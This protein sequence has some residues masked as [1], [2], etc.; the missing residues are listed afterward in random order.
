MSFKKLLLL[1]VLSVVAFTINA[2]VKASGTVYDENNEPVIGATVIQKGNPKVGTAT[3]FDGNFTLTVPAGSHI[4]VTYVG[5][6]PVDMPAASGMK[7]TLK[8]KSDGGINLNEVVV[9]GY[10]KVDKRLFTGATT[11]VDAGKAKLD[12]VADVSRSLEGRAAGVQVQNVSGT[13]G[14]APKIRV[15]GATSIYGSSKPLWVVDGVILEDN[16]DISADDLS[17]GDATTLIASAVAGLNADDIESFQI[18]KDGSAT[19]IYGAKANAGVIVITTK[20]GRKGHT[21]INYTGEFTYRLKPNYR[22]FNIS[23]SQEQIGI[24]REMEQKGW[25]EMASLI[26]GSSTGTYGH[27]YQLMNQYNE[28]NHQFGLENTREA[29]NNYLRAAEMRNTDWFDL[30]F[31]NNIMMNHA[32]SINGGTDKGAFYTSIS[33]MNDPGWYKSSSVERYTF[34]S[35][36]IYQ[37]TDKIRVKILNS[38]S[39]RRQRAP[40]TLS[41]NVDVVSGNVSRSFDINP[42]SFA[43]NTSRALDPTQTYRRNYSDF[44]IFNELQN[45]YI[46]LNVLDVK[47]QGEL[48]IKPIIK[49]DQSL[50]INLLA[51]YRYNNS[52]QNHYVTDNSNQ[53][54]AYRA[55]VDPENAIVRSSNRYLY[56]DPD[57]PNSLPESVLPQGGML[58]Y[59]KYAITQ[60]D[61]R[62]TAQYMKNFNDKHLFQ[63]FAG[64]EASRV[65]RYSQSFQGWGIEYSGHLTTVT[66]KLFKQMEEENGNYFSDSKGYRRN[67]AFFANA[68]YSL[69]GRY[70]LNGTVRYEGSN[71]MGRTRQS[72]WLPTWNISGA[73]N[74]FEENFF[75]EAAFKKWWTYAKL[76]LS[77]SLTGES[78]PTGYANAEAL[79]YPSHPWRPETETKEMGIGLNGLANSELTYEKK[80]EFDVGI[81]LGFI[82]NRINLVFDWYKRNNFDLIGRINTAGVGGV[83]SKWANVA[84]MKSHGVEFTLTT[85]NI[86]PVRPDGFSWTTDLTFSYTHTNITKLDSRSS[87]MD[88]IRGNG[89]PLQGY[90]HRAIFSIPF[91]GLNN[92]GAPQIINEKGEV[93]TNSIN[94][95]EYEKLD[96]LKYEGPVDPTYTGGFGNMF[97]WKGFHLNVFMTYSFGNKL[98]LTPRFSSG[99]SDMTAMPKEFKNRWVIPGDEA[100]TNIPAIASVRQVYNDNQLGWGYNAYNYSTAR[101]AD[102]GFIR[103]KEVSLTY[104]LPT[105]FIRHLRLNSASVKLAATN[106]CLLYA[107]K[108]LNGEDPEFF[109]TGG[110]ASPNPKQLTLTVR[111]G[112]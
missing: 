4:L 7:I 92:Q 65:D 62:A 31:N 25:L 88:L 36:A 39:Y 19:S 74:V 102:G 57:D 100:Y 38:D 80:H 14:T 26:N 23:N 95:Q 76:R 43:L 110:V 1:F 96:F 55:G 32:V 5:Y 86:D 99:Y 73:W 101:I 2:Q 82:N 24:Y 22:D 91:V 70:I 63:I 97:S 3:D 35:N 8:P 48:Q 28:T 33:L 58:F 67:A 45:N 54:L 29:M 51:S 9:T 42:Y 47:F 41:Q 75:R 71:L 109:N 84:E 105:S 66:S 85:K 46:D 53:A 13:F 89:F 93:T 83:I 17:S 56:T 15:R 10:Q 21:S 103:L 44:N 81:D 40:G 72:R 27:M 49:Q 111:F 107:D 18:L 68:N 64:A 106:I 94:F 37:L 104:D 11:S 16:V 78:G 50:E 108:K 60:V 52:E 59:S 20:T 79:Y 30:L 112:L 34:N 61:F 77:Y 87:V 98:R 6:E 69:L 12:G 90:P